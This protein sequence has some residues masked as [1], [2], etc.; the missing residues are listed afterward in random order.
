VA[1]QGENPKF[2]PKAD[3]KVR[4][5]FHTR[6]FSWVFFQEKMKVFRFLDKIKVS[7][8]DSELKIGL[9]PVISGK[10]EVRTTGEKPIFKILTVR[11][12]LT[13]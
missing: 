7:K 4:Q 6:K 1:F 12:H 10:N 5:I 13:L 3:A 11:W 8:G 2:Y 9:F